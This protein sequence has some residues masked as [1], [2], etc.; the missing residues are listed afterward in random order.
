MK[1]EHEK[2]SKTNFKCELNLYNVKLLTVN[3]FPA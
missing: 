1:I 2:G 3:I